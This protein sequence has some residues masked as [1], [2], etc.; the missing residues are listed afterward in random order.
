MDQA[1][2]IDTPAVE[3]IEGKPFVFEFYDAL[4]AMWFCIGVN[5]ER[6]LSYNKLLTKIT[7]LCFLTRPHNRL[8]HAHP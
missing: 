6:R 5:R 3:E 1:V 7:L 8:V 2:F 4:K